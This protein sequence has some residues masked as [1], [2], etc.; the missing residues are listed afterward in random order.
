MRSGLVLQAFF[1]SFTLDL[2]YQLLPTAT[3]NRHAFV[4]T[5]SVNPVP[6]IAG[7]FFFNAL[8]GRWR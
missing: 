2:G 8:L 1:T 4:A 7:L 5:L 6:L 3:D